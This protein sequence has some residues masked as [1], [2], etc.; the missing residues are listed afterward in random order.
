[1]GI[2]QRF[3]DVQGGGAVG[4]GL[5]QVAGDG[6]GAG[7]A[8]QD[9]QA[10]VDVGEAVQSGAEQARGLVR[11]EPG[12]GGVGRGA[13]GVT[14]AGTGVAGGQQVVRQGRGV[15]GVQVGDGVGDPGV[16]AG[17][18]RPGQVL[19][20]GVADDHVREPVTARPVLDQETALGGGLHG[21]ERVTEQVVQEVEVD[22]RADDRRVPQDPAHL[23]GQLGEAVADDVPDAGGDRV[24]VGGEQAGQLADEERVAAAAPVDVV[25]PLLAAG[26]PAD[27]LGDRVPGQSAQVQAT[28]VETGGAAEEGGQ[29][30][31]GVGVAVGGDDQ[32]PRRVGQ[33]GREQVQGLLAGPVEVVEDQQE[34]CGAGEVV[35]DGAVPVEPVGERGRPGPSSVS[36]R[37]VQG[38]AAGVSRV[39]GLAAWAVVQPD[40]ARRSAK[41]STNA[42]FP[43]PASPDTSTSRGRSA[44]DSAAA[45]STAN[46]PAR[47]TNSTPAT[48]A[49]PADP[50][51]PATLADPAD[52]GVV[53][54]AG[55]GGVRV[56]FRMSD[57]R[58]RK[59]GPGSTP[60]SAANRSRA[61]RSTCSASPCRPAWY[62]ANASS[63]HDSSRHGC[64]STCTSRSGTAS[65]DRPSPTS[66]AARRSTA[67]NRNSANRPA[68]ARAHPCSANS[69]YAGPRHNANASS[70]SATDTAEPAEPTDEEPEDEPT[71]ASK[72]QASTSSA[73][74]AY[75][76]GAVTSTRAA[77][78]GA[79][80]GS[81]TRRNADTNVCTAPTAPAGGDSHRSATNRST[82]TTRPR[83]TSNRANTARCRGPGNANGPRGPDATSGPSTPNRTDPTR[84]TLVLSGR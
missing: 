72:R 3:Y 42:V 30:G 40:R 69:A 7:Q 14:G 46:S 81:N 52:P 2:V 55:V 25:G 22:V 47:P 57:S 41:D 32:E 80:S 34:G 27:Q 38:Q 31:T 73:T 12:F 82:G 36:R 60:S 66:A 20:E 11:G 62:W 9:V 49:T 1:M 44:T 45:A 63:R 10:V 29:G 56:W 35:E 79:R 51:T 65:A 18:A 15:V 24:R 75:P 74:S 61:R 17:A 5:D 53:V 33:D 26:G 70:Q 68:S 6:L 58:V 4:A 78:R 54:T 21:V 43:T 13:R 67:S 37:R 16:Q 19:V 83:A 77:A 23:V 50:A 8:H 59:A 39:S 84:A 28:R 71:S 76:G 64:P 48:P